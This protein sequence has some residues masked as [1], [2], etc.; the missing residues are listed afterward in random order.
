MI[1]RITFLFLCL[2]ACFAYGQSESNDISKNDNRALIPIDSLIDISVN[3]EEVIWHDSTKVVFLTLTHH[4]DKY[5]LRHSNLGITKK[6]RNLGGPIVIGNRFAGTCLIYPIL[7]KG[8][9][10]FFLLDDFINLTD[11]LIALS[12]SVAVGEY[13]KNQEFTFFE[14][15]TIELGEVITIINSITANPNSLLGTI[16]WYEKWVQNNPEYEDERIRNFDKQCGQIKLFKAAVGMPVSRYVNQ[17]PDYYVYHDSKD[18]LFLTKLNVGHSSI[19]NRSTTI[20]DSI[21]IDGKGS[22]EI[23]FERTYSGDF[24]NI[25]QAHQEEEFTKIHKYEI[26]NLD[27]KTLLFEAISFY[28]YQ[29]ENWSLVTNYTSNDDGWRR[30][31]CSYSYNFSIDSIG[32]IKISEIKT[33]STNEKCTPDKKEGFYIF[34]NGMYIKV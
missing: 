19:T 9:T 8:N 23:I 5:D 31:F 29:Y 21:Q 11:S 20:V 33:I 32:R 13:D 6:Y 3:I 28:E 10:S 4:D 7:T 27:T 25:M 26:W 16:K 15:P 14:F 2:C 17:A 12:I 34:T 30:G 22:K 24:R 1:M 18:T